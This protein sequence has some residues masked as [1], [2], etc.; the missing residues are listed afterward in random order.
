MT[1][2][3]VVGAEGTE[4]NRA[5]LIWAARAAEARHAPL[6]VVHAVGYP[7]LAV[8]LSYDDA[9]EQAAQAL[10]A[11]AEKLVHEVAPDVDVRTEVR[12]EGAGRALT[13]RS[14]DAQLLVVGTHRLSRVERVLTGS[15][16]YQVAAG[17]ECPVAV[18]PELADDARPRVVV[19]ADGSP[20]ALAAIRA[21]AVEADRAGAELHVVHAWAAPVTYVQL[22]YAIGG[23]DR[24]VEDESRVAL[25][26]SVAGLGEDFP[27]LVVHQH[28]V[29]GDPT[30]VLLEAARDVRLLVVGSRGRQGVAR[31]L[32]GSV[33]HGVLLNATCPVLVVRR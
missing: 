1:R 12:R 4:A 16:A 29:H 11:D 18:V 7:P 3:V 14:A 9:V 10:L 5:A 17:A 20:D 13:T 33:S 27:D 32:L 19:G 23:Y 15:L 24:V 26:E 22:G 2:P 25:A 31:M 6:S 30:A 8:D 28:L 21:A